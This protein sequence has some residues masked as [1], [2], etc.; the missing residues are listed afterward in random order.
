MSTL[1]ELTEDWIQARSALKRQL[2]LLEG[3]PALPQVG[4]TAQARKAIALRLKAAMAEFE[5][6]LKEHPDS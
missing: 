4:L 6:L 5:A 3:D 1:K 2:K